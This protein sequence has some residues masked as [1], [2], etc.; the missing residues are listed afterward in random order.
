MPQDI[1]RYKV[2]RRGPKWCVRVNGT[3]NTTESFRWCRD[4]KMS[5]HIKQH[6]NI[7]KIWYEDRYQTERWDYDFI[8]DEKKEALTFVLGYL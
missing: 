6:W 4:R 8:F 2:V 5:Y 3:I 1:E 7:N